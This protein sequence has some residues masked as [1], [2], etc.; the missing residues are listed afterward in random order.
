MKIS[1]LRLSCLRNIFLASAMTVLGAAAWAHGDV[2]PQ[3]V[4]TKTLPQLGSK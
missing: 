2:T 4:D 3:A 1:S